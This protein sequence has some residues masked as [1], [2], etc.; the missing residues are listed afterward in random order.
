MIFLYTITYVE[1]LFNVPI[2]LTLAGKCALG[3]SFQ[4]IARPIVVTNVYII[5]SW[6]AYFVANPLA[7]WMLVA[8]A[9][10][11]YA[12]ASVDMVGWVQKFRRECKNV[13]STTYL[14]PY[15]TFGLIAIF[16]VYGLVYVAAML[17]LITRFQERMFYSS[18]D[19]ASKITM[20]IAFGGIRASEYHELLITYLVNSN[21]PFKR[22]ESDSKGSEFSLNSDL[23]RPFV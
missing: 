23:T 20:S 22:Q 7:R 6:M 5:L 19:I 13:S 10:S 16:G 8:L 2:L 21:L 18:A 14:K 17:S 3:N 12:F 1:W 15:L 9:F 4:D 11:M